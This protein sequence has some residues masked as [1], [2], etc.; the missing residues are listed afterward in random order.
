VTG[1][2]YSVP[3]NTPKIPSVP[4]NT[5]RG[6]GAVRIQL[7]LNP[8]GANRTYRDLLRDGRG[9]RGLGQEI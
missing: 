5:Q 4:E 8:A 1:N 7:D 2:W 3:E 6:W 9:D